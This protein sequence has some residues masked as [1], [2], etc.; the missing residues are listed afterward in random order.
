MDFQRREF[1]HLFHQERQIVPGGLLR[2][3]SIGYHC[4]V[5]AFFAMFIFQ[6]DARPFR[7]YNS[8]EYT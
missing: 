3:N 2:V 5:T 4:M 8:G 7:C 1:L 6:I